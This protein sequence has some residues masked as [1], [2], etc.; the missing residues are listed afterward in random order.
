MAEAASAPGDGKKQQILQGAALVF[1]ADGYEGASMSRI[2]A[3]A[4]VSKGTLYNY[5]PGKAELFAD[6]VEQNCTRSIILVFDELEQASPPETVLR[7]IGMRLLRTLLSEPAL[8]IHR[9]VVAEAGKFPELAQ[10]FN[11]AG[12]A[13]GQAHLSGFLRRASQAG[14]LHVED[15]ESAAEQFLALVLKMVHMRRTLR[16]IEMP[17]EAEIARVVDGA[18]WLFMRGYGV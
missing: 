12:P 6:Y 8:V 3:E 13:K 17:S 14:R 9:M 11:A 1:A 4:G 10:A 5:F 2:A 7:E 15:P 18:V 16:L